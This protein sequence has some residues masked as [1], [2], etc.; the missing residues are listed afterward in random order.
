MFCKLNDNFKV[1][2]NLSN[3]GQPSDKQARPGWDNQCW[4]LSKRAPV[5][6]I[7]LAHSHMGSWPERT[8]AKQNASRQCTKM[9]VHKSEQKSNNSPKQAFENWSQP[10]AAWDCIQY[11]RLHRFVHRLKSRNKQVQTSLFARQTIP[12]SFRSLDAPKRH[13]LSELDWK[14]RHESHKSGHFCKPHWLR[15]QARWQIRSKGK[16][17]SSP[18]SFSSDSPRNV[19]NFLNLTGS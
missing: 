11:K 2:A 12:A 19:R 5:R 16:E 15:I 6:Q 9:D 10:S 18:F 4:D 13:N 17:L 14:D 1:S 7:A 8:P 3:A